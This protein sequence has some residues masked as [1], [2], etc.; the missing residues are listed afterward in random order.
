MSGPV[1]R[2]ATHA[3][4]PALIE[5][6]LRL[7]RVSPYVT[8]P[9][10][11]DCA[12]ATMRRCISS[13]SGRLAL[14]EHRGKIVGAL[15]GETVQFWWGGRHYATDHAMFSTVPGVGAALIADFCQ[16]AWS[17]PNVVEVLLGQSSGDEP[18]RTRAMFEG[19]GFERAGG[20]Y[21][22]SRYDATMRGAA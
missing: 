4:I 16:W 8:T 1:I 13:P 9:H 18:E 5:H 6:F 3:D 19:L 22:L 12:R 21:R 11:L 17:R 10:N 20:I 14:A 7:K 2:L 15:M